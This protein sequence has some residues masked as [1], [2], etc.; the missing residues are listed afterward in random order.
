MGKKLLDQV[1]DQI[2]V[3]HYSIKTEKSYQALHLL[4]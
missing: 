1:R 4:P 2:R 3:R